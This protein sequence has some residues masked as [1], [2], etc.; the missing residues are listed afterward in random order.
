LL[1]DRQ[2]SCRCNA[3]NDGASRCCTF[4][5]CIES[6]SPLSPIPLFLSVAFCCPAFNLS[7]PSRKALVS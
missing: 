2:C 4:L 5:V 7:F 3:D 1:W 6:T